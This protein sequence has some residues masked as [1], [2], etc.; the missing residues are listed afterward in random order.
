[1]TTDKEIGMSDL[2]ET[3]DVVV[4]GGGSATSRGN[5]QTPQ[6]PTLP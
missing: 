2:T 4:V 3:A 5:D 1:M 6:I